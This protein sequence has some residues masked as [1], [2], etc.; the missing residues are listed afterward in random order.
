MAGGFDGNPLM[1]GG[2]VRSGDTALQCPDEAFPS[3]C[4]VGFQD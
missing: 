4:D 1:A 2:S 3:F